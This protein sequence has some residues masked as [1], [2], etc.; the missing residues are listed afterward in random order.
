VTPI[1]RIDAVLDLLANDSMLKP[2]ATDDDI[3]AALLTK[4]PQLKE[5]EGQ[6][7]ELLRML[8]KLQKDGYADVRK[9]FTEFVGH[10]F[11]NPYTYFITFE[12]AL[13][14]QQGGYQGQLNRQNVEKIR[15]DKLAYDNRAN[16]KN[17]VLL[18]FV[19]AVAA[20]IPALYYSLEIRQHHHGFYQNV[21]PFALTGILA[22]V[23]CTGLY[24]ILKNRQ[25]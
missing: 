3:L 5:N 1:Q 24:I 15:A 22:L 2:F 17:T 14:H 23:L 4:Y 7:S 12:G 16:Q 20:I 10:K 25:P 21:Y 19:L 18:T 11:E 8:E 6:T 9:S 13:F